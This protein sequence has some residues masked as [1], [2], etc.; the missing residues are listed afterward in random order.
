[1]HNLLSHFC[2][3]AL[4]RTQSHP[5][6][7]PELTADVGARPLRRGRQQRDCWRQPGTAR[8]VGV[9]GLVKKAMGPVAWDFGLL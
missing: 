5:W 7:G 2:G 1:M 3:R 9:H 4:D 8:Q 6:E